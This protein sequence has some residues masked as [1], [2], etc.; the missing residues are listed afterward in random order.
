MEIKVLKN[1]L[2]ANEQIAVQNH[3]LLNSKGIFAVNIMSSPGAGKTSLIVETIKALKGRARIGVI[4]GDVAGSVDAE[5]V[6]KEQVPVIQINTG[7]QC[8][9]DANM[10][11]N[12]LENLPLKDIDIL[13]IENVGNLICTADFALGEHKKIVISSVPEGDDKPIKYP[14]I[15]HTA[16]AVVINKIDLIPYVKYDLQAFLKGVRALNKSAEIFQV[17]CTTGWGVEEWACWLLNQKT[18]G[19]SPF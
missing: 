5:R 4:E 6:D 13:F 11:R 17:S 1:I 7:G 18:A 15:F 9:L 10:V 8:H 14:M 16:D 3:Q 19:K 12:A 2:G